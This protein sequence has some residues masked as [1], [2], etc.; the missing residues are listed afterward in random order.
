M[1]K[2]MTTIDKAVDFHNVHADPI[3]AEMVPR[4]CRWCRDTA[5][6][7]IK[8]A[9]RSL[10]TIAEVLWRIENGHHNP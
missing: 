3:G 5:I 8:K 9:T 1:M 10:F 6:P 2:M 7:T 4:M